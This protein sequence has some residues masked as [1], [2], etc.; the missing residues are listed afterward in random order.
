MVDTPK[1]HQYLSGS[2]STFCRCNPCPE[3][4]GSRGWSQQDTFAAHPPLGFPQPPKQKTADTTL[5]VQLCSWI[6]PRCI[7]MTLGWVHCSLMSTP[8]LYFCG[9]GVPGSQIHTVLWTQLSI[10]FL[11][12]KSE[13][14]CSRSDYSLPDHCSA[15]NLFTTIM[16]LSVLLLY[17]E[18]QCLPTIASA[19]PEVTVFLDDPFHHSCLPP[20]FADVGL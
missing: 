18:N 1:S 12:L 8:A 14:L 19:A 5:S 17:V 16:A 4:I 10:S 13:R 3:N 6:P 9:P 7:L 2:L 11:W 15:R 20:Q